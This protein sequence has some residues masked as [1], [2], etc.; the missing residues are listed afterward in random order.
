M[1][2]KREL[3]FV[4]VVKIDSICCYFIHVGIGIGIGIG[5][6]M[7]VDYNDPPE[8]HS[9][10]PAHDNCRSVDQPQGATLSVPREVGGLMSQWTP[11]CCE[12]NETNR[13]RQLSRPHYHH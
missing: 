2:M 3:G 6:G 5:I 13:S 4:C 12:G 9:L 10:T 1:M 8:R 7:G 11:L